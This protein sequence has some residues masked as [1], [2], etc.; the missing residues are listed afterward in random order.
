MDFNNY[1]SKK[2]VSNFPEGQTNVLGAGN[3]DLKIVSVHITDDQHIGLKSPKLKEVLPEWKD[4][5][6]QVA[7]VFWHKN[8]V[9]TRRFNG[10]GFV[11]FADI[12]EAEQ[13]LYDE[14][15]I[16]GYAVSK[17][18]GTRVISKKN[19]ESCENILNQFFDACKLPEGSVLEDLPNCM[20]N[21]T[22]EHNDE[23]GNDDV[24]SFK[25]IGVSSVI[26]EEVP[27]ET[28]DY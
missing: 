26:K 10:H 17:E 28:G 7:V 21:V 1:Q 4:A 19:T 22:I 2:H 24:K 6:P 18:T 15:G 5:T 13:H 14:L 16:A 23:Y 11:R 25:R 9:T 12:A 3:Y 27:E 8:G 20:V